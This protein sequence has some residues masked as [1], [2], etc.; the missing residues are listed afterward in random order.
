MFEVA[1]F[2]FLTKS[3]DFKFKFTKQNQFELSYSLGQLAIG[4]HKHGLLISLEEP[5]LD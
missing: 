5:H 1:I 3:I 2:N 4:R